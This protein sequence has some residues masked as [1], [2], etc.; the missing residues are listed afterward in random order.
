M[1]SNLSGADDSGSDVFGTES[2]DGVIEQRIRSVEEAAHGMRLDRWLVDLAPEFSRT[3]LQRLIAGGDVLINGRPVLTAS[4]RLTLGQSVQVNLRLPLEM[5]A[6]RAEAMALDVVFEDADCLVL[7]KPAGLVMHPAAGNWSGTVLNGLLAHHAGAMSLPRAGIVHRLDK[8]TSG[9]CVVGKT[10]L[11]TRRLSEA[12][13]RREVHRSYL[14]L[15]H[16]RIAESRFTADASI[17]RDPASRVRMAVVAGGR[18]A[19]TDVQRLCERELTPRQWVSAVSCVLHTGRTHQIR[20]HLMHRGHPLVADAVY[21]GALLLGLKRQALH[22]H[23]L[24]FEHP[25]THAPM[26]FQAALPQDMQEAWNQVCP[27]G[28]RV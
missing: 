20:V 22:A 3:H 21:G 5:T 23:E 16:G 1:D 2:N 15:V 28:A 9:L 8:D 11:A 18:E 4:R 13:A 27:E 19:R 10:L 7:N 24:A 12:I 25:V 14:A 6:F 17:G 26:A